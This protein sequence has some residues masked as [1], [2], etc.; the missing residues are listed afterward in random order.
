[1]QYPKIV[2][3]E[4]I[5]VS[6]WL[7]LIKKVV[8][9]APLGLAET[10]H[11]VTQNAYV[12]I[13]ART[14]DAKIV[15]VRQYRPCVEDYTWEFPAGTLEECETPEQA[16]R[17]ELLEETGL[18]A[19]ELISLGNFHP[20][21]GRLQIDSHSFYVR[22]SPTGHGAGAEPGITV[23]HVTHAEF[24]S[25]IVSGEFRHQLHLAIYAAVLARGIILD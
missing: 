10:Y 3:R 9:Y 1:M 17:R 24:K 21:T 15:L 5:P 6:P 19:D 12:G 7:D 25:M 4:C 8:Q 16:A 23:R 14:P 11:C 2:S 18:L 22:V 20:D 13:L